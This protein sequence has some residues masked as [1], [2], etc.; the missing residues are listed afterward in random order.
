MATKMIKNSI[1]KIIACP[2]CKGILEF[3]KK[4]KCRKCKLEFEIKDNSPVLIIDKND[5]I[6]KK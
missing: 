2:K 1:K 5:K 4:L 3:K 6:N